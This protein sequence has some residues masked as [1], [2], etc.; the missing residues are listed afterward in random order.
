VLDTVDYSAF[1]GQ[2]PGNHNIFVVTGDSGQG[3]T[4]GA[5]SGLLL[6]D[7]ILSGSSPWSEVYDPGRKP[8]RRQ[9]FARQP[10]RQ[11][12]SLPASSSLWLCG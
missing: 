5:L 3:I 9:R 6:R 7:L 4:H 11:N 12:R 10:F 1:I 8:A 2:N